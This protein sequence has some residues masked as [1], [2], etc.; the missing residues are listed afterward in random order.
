MSAKETKLCTFH[1]TVGSSQGRFH[2]FL[3]TSMIV[4]LV[5]VAHLG[6]EAQRVPKGNPNFCQKLGKTIQAST[7]AQMFCFPPKSPTAATALASPSTSTLTF[8]SN[9]DAATLS[10]DVTPSGVQIH[11]QS[12]V[13][14]AAAGPYVVE[15]W[16]DGTGL[17][18]TLRLTP[19]QGGV[20]R[21]CFL[22]QWRRLIH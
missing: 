21:V 9:V 22:K 8:G 16:N 1:A 18:C 15:A 3:L 19:K 20:D 13:S 6:A 14:V 17:L 2:R 11:G 7:G 12:E 10:E 5:V 4:L